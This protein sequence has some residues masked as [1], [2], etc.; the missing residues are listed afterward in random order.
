MIRPVDLDVPR[1]L[2][3]D[4]CAAAGIDA[5]T[6]KNWMVERPDARTPPPILL[7]KTDR[8]A[9]G[10]G[11][12]NLFTFRRAMQISLLADLVRLGFQPRRAGVIAAGFTD[13][14]NDKTSSPSRDPGELYA[15]GFT[16]LLAFPDSG[17]RVDLQCQS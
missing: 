9:A 12:P 17:L 1:Y 4:V 2:A 6:L 7:D 16:L 13:F 8:L 11:R 10:S 15:D 5:A 14:G 3:A